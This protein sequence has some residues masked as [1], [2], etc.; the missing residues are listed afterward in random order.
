[1]ESR[2]FNARPSARTPYFAAISAATA[3]HF[4]TRRLAITHI[5]ASLGHAMGDAVSNARG[6]PGH[7]RDLA[8]QNIVLEHKRHV[9]ASHSRI[10]VMHAAF[11]RGASR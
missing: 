3:S 11:G 1:L 6:A 9:H 5:G 7:E 10:V 2:T 8:L 4:S